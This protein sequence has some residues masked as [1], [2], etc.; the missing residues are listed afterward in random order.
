MLRQREADE[1]DPYRTIPPTTTGGSTFPGGRYRIIRPH[2]KGG[3][4]QVFVAH[5]TELNSAR[6]RSSSFRTG[7]PTIRKFGQRFE[8]EAEVTGGLEHPGMVPVYR[9][10][11]LAGAGRSMRCGSSR[12]KPQGRDRLPCGRHRPGRDPGPRA[13]IAGAVR[14]VHRRLRRRRVCP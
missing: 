10:G 1:D 2:A 7:S 3:L 4:G 14:E 12:G 6:L 13:G 9:L 8:F 11:Q 5:D